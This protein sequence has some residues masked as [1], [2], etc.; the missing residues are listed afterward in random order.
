M[1]WER[2]KT[3]ISY[4]SVT[5]IGN[6]IKLMQKKFKLLNHLL[7]NLWV[8]LWHVGYRLMSQ[9]LT[10]GISCLISAWTWKFFWASAFLPMVSKDWLK[11]SLKK[12]SSSI[13]PEAVWWSFVY[14]M[15][16]HVTRLNWWG[17]GDHEFTILG[18]WP[19]NSPYCNLIE[20]LELVLFFKQIWFICQSKY[21]KLMTILMTVFH[22]IKEI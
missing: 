3:R 16:L 1:I 14:S 9:I 22:F 6:K 17:L 10:D 5:F 7:H 4:V 20:N 11:M 2:T 18:P 12:T 21:L 8:S 15:L 19:W 13:D